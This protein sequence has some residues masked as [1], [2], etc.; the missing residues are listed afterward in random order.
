M[1]T[2]ACG[3]DGTF[4][5]VCRHVGGKVE[6]VKGEGERGLEP[7]GAADATDDGALVCL[8]SDD[9]VD[10]R[11]WPDLKHEA[12]YDVKDELSANYS[13]IRIEQRFVVSATFEDDEDEERAL[14]LKP[15]L[16]LEDDAPAPPGMWAGRLGLDRIVT[17]SREKGDER[18]VF[19]YS[20]EV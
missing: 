9:H 6:L 7:C 1:L 11:R 10:L 16:V 20:M 18:R 5:R 15:G 13:G 14:V 12:R 4:I 2:M 17:I 3:Q 8:V 19:V